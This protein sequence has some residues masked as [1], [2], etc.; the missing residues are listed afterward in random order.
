MDYRLL[1]PSLYI[2]AADL[3]GQEK[4]L[5]IRRVVV[6][7]LKTDRGSE[8]KPVVYFEEVRDKADSSK[9]KRLVLN[10]TNAKTIA[11]VYDENEIDNWVGKRITLFPSTVSVGG[12]MRDCIRVR[13]TIPQPPKE[14]E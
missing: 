14:K 8:K 13:P 9:D 1:F 7:E 2:G 5:T 3:R 12:E 6:E 10:K 11:K 4:T